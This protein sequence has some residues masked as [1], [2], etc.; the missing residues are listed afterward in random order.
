MASAGIRD[1]RVPASRKSIFLPVMSKLMSGSGSLSLRVMTKFSLATLFGV[2]VLFSSV[3]SYP[4]SN[5]SSYV[6][7]PEDVLSVTI[8]AGGKSE[9]Q[10][11]ITVSSNG[12]I[13][14]PFLGQI[15]AEGLTVPKLVDLV[16][17]PLAEDYFVNPQVIINIKEHKSKK[18]YITG[19]V[20]KPGLYPLDTATTL[21]ELIAKA[22]GVNKERGHFAHILKGSVEELKDKNSETLDQLIEKKKTIKIDLRELLDQ[23]MADRNIKLDP[24]DV[25]YI[26]P[27]AFSAAAQYKVYVLG[28]VKTPGAYEY[29]E[30]LTALD[31]CVLAGGFDKYSAPNRTV[32]TRRHED[33]TVETLKVDLDLVKKGE[34]KDLL[35]K[36]GDRIYVPKSWF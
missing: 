22:G 4:Q 16:T 21:L 34:E 9:E 7:G 6:I 12:M 27:S 35:L 15:R 28:K 30:G 20:E 3:V 10:L 23:G 19:A 8:F 13:N 14:F 2:M 24:G 31:A 29:Q 36:P 18:V 17:K 5:P 33:G 25:I 11:D 1:R 32:I 26:Q